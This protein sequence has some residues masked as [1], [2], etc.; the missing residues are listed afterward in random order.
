MDCAPKGV[1][2]MLFYY[3]PWSGSDGRHR[4]APFLLRRTETLAADPQPSPNTRGD[5]AMSDTH[6]SRDGTCLFCETAWAGVS[7]SLRLSKREV[8][9]LQCLILGD[10]E[11]EVALFIG[12][13]CRTVRTHLERI[14]WKLGVH[15]RVE[16]IVRLCDAHL[17]WL[18]EASPP[19]GCRLNGRLARIQ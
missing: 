1:P 10:N 7:Q 19:M 18:C 13:T 4:T 8:E 3:T 12:L 14:R 5:R 2:F 6:E 15:T 11:R 17:D 9:I 16:L